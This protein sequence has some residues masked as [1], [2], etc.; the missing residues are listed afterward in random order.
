[1]AGAKSIATLLAVVLWGASVVSP[2]MHAQAASQGGAATVPAQLS[3]DT[4]R[5]MLDGMGYEP[6]AIS[7][8]FL[9]VIKRDAWTCNIQLVLSDNKSKLGMNANLGLVKDP[10]RVAAAQWKALMAVNRDI[11]PSFFY[12][13]ADSKKLFLHRSID[14][15]GLTPAYMRSQIEAFVE[16]MKSTAEL[17]KF[18]E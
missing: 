6:K 3:N 5:Q 17:W 12:F 15:R 1:M 2:N 14:N 16:N 8:G 10:D 13:D 11:D 4:L 9:V 7:K 18:T